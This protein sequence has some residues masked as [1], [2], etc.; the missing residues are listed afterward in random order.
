MALHLNVFYLLVV[1]FVG[2]SAEIPAV[3]RTPVTIPFAKIS[4][5][6]EEKSH[7]FEKVRVS[8]ENYPDYAEI[9]CY[10]D[11]L[12]KIRPEGRERIAY[13]EAFGQEFAISEFEA[14]QIIRVNKSLAAI[15][16]EVERLLQEQ[17]WDKLAY[18]DAFLP[19]ILKGYY[20]LYCGSRNSFS[21]MPSIA[22]VPDNQ[23]EASLNSRITDFR[24]Y[25]WQRNPEKVI[26]LRIVAKELLFQMDAWEK[27]E[28]TS[29]KR[30]KEISYGKSFEETFAMF[31]KLY[32]NI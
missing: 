15:I 18:I 14:S 5:M 1:C 21:E 29:K 23:F 26:R 32:F 4:A 20:Y 16:K 6:L 9:T 11:M 24:I 2:F 31:V 17:K 22:L 13:Q 3:K 27:K 8:W 25:G 7:S 10:D 19:R 30:N 12:F 28:L